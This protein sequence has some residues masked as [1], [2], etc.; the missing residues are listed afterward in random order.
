MRKARGADTVDNMLGLF[1][2]RRSRA[3][4]SA[5]LYLQ[6]YLGSILIAGDWET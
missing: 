2:A 3:Q 6:R 4:A 5:G 1:W